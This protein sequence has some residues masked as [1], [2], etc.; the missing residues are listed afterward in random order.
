[1]QKVT[2]LLECKQKE[3]N[4][5]LCLRVKL[6]EQRDEQSPEVCPCNRHC[7]ELCGMFDTT[8]RNLLSA[9]LS[10]LPLPLTYKFVSLKYLALS[11]L[12]FV[13]NSLHDVQT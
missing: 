3:A 13:N 1:M 5:N 9:D 2:L 10:F 6:P 11:I 12:Q 4:T 8:T 7:P